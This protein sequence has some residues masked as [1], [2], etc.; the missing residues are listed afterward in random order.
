VPA[1]PAYEQVRRAF[2]DLPAPRRQA[3]FLAFY[4]GLTY[5]EVARALDIPEGTAMWRMRNALRRIGEQL[6]SV[7]CEDGVNLG[8]RGHRAGQR[9]RFA[10]GAGG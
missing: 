10:G 7:G 1:S 9:R 4:H 5:R 3:I 6:R 8:D 2:A